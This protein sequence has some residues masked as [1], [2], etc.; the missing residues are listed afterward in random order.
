MQVGSRILLF[1][2]CRQSGPPAQGVGVLVQLTGTVNQF[3]IETAEEAVP[4]CIDPTVLL[5]GVHEFNTLAVR[6]DHKLP[7]PEDMFKLLQSQDNGCQFSFV[8]RVVALSGTA[9]LGGTSQENFMSILFLAQDGSHVGTAVVGVQDEGFRIVVLRITT[10]WLGFEALLQGVELGLG[11][12]IPLH[13]L[14]HLVL[15]HFSCQVGIFLDKA[16]V[17]A[18]KSQEGPEFLSGL[19]K[20]PIQNSFYIGRDHFDGVFGYKVSEVLHF[21]LDNCTLAHVQ[22]HA[23]FH[24]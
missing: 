7:G 1:R 6:A 16:P 15:V 24:V 14:H 9:L 18:G 11:V 3:V 19:G 10:Y 2:L 23:H 12:I 5:H 22:F 13:F 17:I 4:P 8:W 20:G 21:C